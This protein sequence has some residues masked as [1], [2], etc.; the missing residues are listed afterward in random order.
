MTKDLTEKALEDMI[1]EINQAVASGERLTIKPTVV[2]FY[3]E[4]V[5][6][7][8]MERFIRSQH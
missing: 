4:D 2:Y 8:T 7:E 5:S 6:R 1:G 3:P